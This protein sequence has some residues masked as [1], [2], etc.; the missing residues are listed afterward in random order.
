MCNEPFVNK[1]GTQTVDTIT[2][3]L[4]APVTKHEDHSSVKWLAANVEGKTVSKS[5]AVTRNVVYKKLRASFTCL[6]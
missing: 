3:D 6:I 5:M 2:D 1:P 4:E